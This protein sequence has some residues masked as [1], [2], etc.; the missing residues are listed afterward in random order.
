MILDLMI[1]RTHWLHLL[2]YEYQYQYGR[3]SKET[4]SE[5]YV[6]TGYLHLSSVKMTESSKVRTQ[7]AS[8][9]SVFDRLYKSSTAASRS[10]LKTHRAASRAPIKNIAVDDDCSKIFNR[11]Y[12]SGTISNT[13]KRVNPR[14]PSTPSNKNTVRSPL[15]RTPAKTPSTKSRDSFVYSPVSQII[16]QQNFS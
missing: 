10:R 14:H 11:L 16:Y 9:G 1:Y 5:G 2:P 7:K 3:N 6:Y 12:I 13:S 15:N 8:A 4:A